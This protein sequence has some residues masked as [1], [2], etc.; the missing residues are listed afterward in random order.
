M[1]KFLD[2]HK[3]NKRF[4]SQFQKKFQDVLDSGYYILGDEVVNFETNFATYCQPNCAVG[5]RTG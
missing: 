1:I 3:I 5:V 2:V 4:E